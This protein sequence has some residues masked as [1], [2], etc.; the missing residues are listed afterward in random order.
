MMG[1]HY[2]SALQPSYRCG[3]VNGH[4]DLNRCAIVGDMT[5]LNIL[6]ISS[7]RTFHEPHWI[8]W[9]E[10][11]ALWRYPPAHPS[12]FGGNPRWCHQFNT[13][14]ALPR[15]LSGHINS[16]TS[17]QGQKVFPKCH[18]CEALIRPPQSYS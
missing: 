5:S 17:E 12:Y 9:I 18:R 8:E 13:P 10:L 15:L 11:N 6:D 14:R 1:V 3:P 2:A 16:L 4:L 7:R